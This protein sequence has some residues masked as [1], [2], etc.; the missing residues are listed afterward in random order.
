MQEHVERID[1]RSVYDGSIIEVF[2]DDIKLTDGNVEKWD[3]VDH[4]MGAAAVLAVLKNGKI[5][6]VRQYRPALDRYTLEIP[7]GARDDVNES[8]ETCA[9][10]ELT[11]ETGYIPGSM[12]RILSLKTTVAFCNEP[13][14]VYLADNLENKVTQSLDE[15]ENIELEEWELSDLLKLI[16]EGT[17]QDSKTVSA[18]LAYNVLKR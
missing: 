14:D 13:I 16:F 11:E 3:F 7:A 4:K 12:K 1:R 15:A 9:R 18:I 2:Q 5:L 10:R 17:I 6:M 8:T